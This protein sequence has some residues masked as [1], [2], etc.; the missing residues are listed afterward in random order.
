MS[1]L[2]VI[3]AVATRPSASRSAAFAAIRSASLLI[4]SK[5]PAYP[6]SAR[7]FA[8]STKTFANAT[9]SERASV[10]FYAASIS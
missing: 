6:L 8:D 5:S 10:I 7:F 3:R 1:V 9:C 4:V 2:S